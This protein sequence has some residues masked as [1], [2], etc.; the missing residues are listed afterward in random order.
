[1]FFPELLCIEEIG[2]CMKH[3]YKNWDENIFNRYLERFQLPPKKSVK[4]FSKGMKMKLGLMVALSH[5]P[6]IFDSSA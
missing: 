6:E 3:I 5:N 2:H 4:E 1:M